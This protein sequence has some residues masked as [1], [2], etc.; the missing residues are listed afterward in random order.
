MQIVKYK[1]AALGLG[2]ESSSKLQPLDFSPN[3]INR[4]YN[5]LGDLEKRRGLQQL[6]AQINNV[7]SV[8]A[9]TSCSAIITNLHEYID[10]SGNST[11][12]ASGIAAAA[13]A[14]YGNIWRY[15]PVSAYW[16]DALIDPVFPSALA[17]FKK[18]PL[19][20]YS[21][22]MGTKLIFCNG[23]NRNFYIDKPASDVT[24]Q[25]T[26]TLFSTVV[27]GVLGSGTDQV[28]IVDPDITNWKTQTNVAVNDLVQLGAVGSGALLNYPGA[29]I[30]TS[31]GTTSLDIT[32]ISTSG[33]GMGAGVTPIAGLPYRIIDLVELNIF[34]N[35]VVGYTLFDNVAIG[36]AQTS[37]NAISVTSF[38]FSSS[39]IRSGDYVY[40]TTR[41]AVTQI[42]TV[43]SNISVSYPISGQAA[44]DSLVFFKD[45]MPIA[46]YPHVHYG[47]L[48]LIDARDQ[49]KIRVS[50]PDDPEDFTTFSKT[51]SSVTMDYGARQPKGDI[52]LTMSTFQRYLVVGGKVGLFAT[53]GTN[54][55]ADVTADVI[56]LDPVGL[57][58]QGVFSPLGLKSIGNEMLY[59][60]NDGMRSFLAAF[61]SKNTTTNNKSEQIKTEL[62]NAL[63]AQAA[64]LDQVQL[65][66]YPRRNWVMMK[67]GDVIYNYNYTPMYSNG[68]VN[69]TG[70]FTKFT[71]LLGQQDAFL[72]TR[73][74]D[75]ITADS[76]GRVFTFDVS[77]IFTDNGTNIA[78]TYVSPWHTLQE[79]ETNADIIIKD[80]R[81][82]RPVFET[83]AA[84]KYNISV[85][86]DY[87]QLAT[88]SVIVTATTSGIT[89]PKCPL[90]WRGRQAQLT[91]TTDTS[92]G[93]DILS[94]Y[95]LYG[96]IF[97]RK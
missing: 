11:L 87:N 51:L 66:H 90:R 32:R 10:S 71:G 47:R 20:I 56:D 38:N 21:V 88:D 58:T 57:F 28:T 3:I 95:T 54:P 23:S 53:D 12:F 29:G 65:I 35:T 27:K 78:T 76:T 8:S 25:Y 63:Q 92:V 89:D 75:L 69:N 55:I 50:G 15:N 45:A 40:N 17:L 7:G 68:K 97:G 48:H 94:S 82:I 61:D 73:A 70:T 39:D 18:D 5:Y 33:N 46:T 96:N 42:T 44:G 79:A 84:I 49:T 64:T 83:S 34:P 26:N 59:I 14:S 93:A 80:G 74:G 2:T 41:A 22:Q 77:G 9:L 52:L 85:V 4:F 30:V 62:I 1:P 19:K 81:Y 60:G 72:V 31:V 36:G 86:G 16:Q 67:I 43:T 24:A 37:A 91:I 13:S 6:G